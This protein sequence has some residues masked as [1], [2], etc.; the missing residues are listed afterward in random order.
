MAQSSRILSGRY[1]RQRWDNH[2]Y[3]RNRHTEDSKQRNTGKLSL[4]TDENILDRYRPLFMPQTVAVVGASATGRGRQNVFIR[5]IREMGYCGAIYPIHPTAA[6]IDGLPAYRSLAE[7]PQPIDYAS[8]AVAAAQ[9]PPLLASARGRVRYVQVISSGFSETNDGRE[10]QHALCEA[11][12]VGGMRLVGPNCLGIYSPRGRITFTETTSCDLGHVGILSQSGG[13]GID[14]LRRGLVR[15]LRFSGVV[16]LGNC[17]D[18]CPSDLLEFFL[19]DPQTKIIGMYL[20]SAKDGRRLFDVLRAGG[21][22]KPVL[23]LKGGRSPEGV[24]AASSHTGAL[25]GSERGWSALARQTGCVLVDT[26]NHFIDT[27]LAF[28]KLTP[29]ANGATRRIVLFGNGGGISVLATDYFSDAGLKVTPFEKEVQDALVALKLPAGASVANPVD[30]PAGA[31]EHEDGRI[32]ERILDA[33]YRFGKP[34]A[35]V[36]H[37]NLTPFVGR[38]KPGTLENLM[39]AVLR[40]RKRYPGQAHFALVLRSD[41]EARLDDAKRKFRQH[42]TELGI[43]VFD[44]LDN[45][46]YALAKLRSYEEFIQSRGIKALEMPHARSISSTN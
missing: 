40:V 24:A 44:E 5:R 25:A 16:T 43:P 18:L 42:A 39:D 37:L 31:L 46:G 6:Q 36:M 14:I 28:D 23:I 11:A 19:A 38:A 7:T 13:L 4:M 27:L 22:R 12:R 15:G 32:A 30:C 2:C 41:G 34:D 26:I 8:I 10:L 20:E 1:P 3:S 21:A 35:L 17:A 45:A 9:I 33:I 29:R